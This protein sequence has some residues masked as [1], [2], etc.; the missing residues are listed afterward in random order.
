MSAVVDEDHFDL[1]PREEWYEQI[2]RYGL[3]VGAAFQ[4]CCILAIIVFPPSSSE[5]AEDNS[6]PVSLK[7]FIF[8]YS[9]RPGFSNRQ[10][11]NS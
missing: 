1:I 5:L 4:L 3:Y 10:L 2:L 6:G 7:C 11:K 8:A 9:L